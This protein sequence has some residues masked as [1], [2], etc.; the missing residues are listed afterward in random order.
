MRVHWFSSHASNTVS[1][2]HARS[3]GAARCGALDQEK[4]P[5]YPVYFV[6]FVRYR[7]AGRTTLKYGCSL[8][9]YRGAGQLRYGYLRGARCTRVARTLDRKQY[10][11]SRKA[12]RRGKEKRDRKSPPPEMDNPPSLPLFSL[13][14]LALLTHL[15]FRFYSLTKYMYAYISLNIIPSF[16]KSSCFFF[17]RYAD[18]L[19]EHE[20]VSRQ[21]ISNGTIKASGKTAGTRVAHAHFVQGLVSPLRRV[22]HC[23][24]AVGSPSFEYA[25]FSS[26]SVV[27]LVKKS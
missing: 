25:C 2:N 1:S 15:F 16:N 22:S 21:K 14:R 19:Y 10:N 12:I 20:S 11:G 4:N 7:A 5:P 9:K 27:V 6:Q 24:I 8:K 13:S 26:L 3:A 17:V 23:P 18:T